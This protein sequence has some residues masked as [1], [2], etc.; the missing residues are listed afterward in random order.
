MQL[1]ISV[2]HTS[3]CDI[4]TTVLQRPVATCRI[5]VRCQVIK[6]LKVPIAVRL[7]AGRSSEVESSAQHRPQNFTLCD[8]PSSKFLHVGLYDA[9]C[10]AITF[11]HLYVCVC[12]VSLET[13]MNIH[14][15]VVYYDYDAE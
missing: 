1:L 7:P 15:R 10:D 9:R 12:V 13:E 2:V 8:V 4:R 5:E 6:Q 3:D 11:S 14:V